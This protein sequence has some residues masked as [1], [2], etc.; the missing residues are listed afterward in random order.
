[1]LRVTYLWTV[2]CHNSITHLLLRGNKSIIGGYIK[3]SNV[4]FMDKYPFYDMN[5]LGKIQNKEGVTLGFGK[6]PGSQ[7]HC[8]YTYSNWEKSSNGVKHNYTPFRI[9]FGPIPD[10]DHGRNQH[11]LI[12]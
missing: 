5:F 2:P 10:K 7:N 4:E 11:F 3:F 9:V 12:C 6:P 1:M 8:F